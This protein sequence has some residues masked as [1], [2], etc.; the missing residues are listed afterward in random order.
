MVVT[1]LNSSVARW[2]MQEKA[3]CVHSSRIALR[4]YI[5]SLKMKE[6]TNY[7][8]HTAFTAAAS[9]SDGDTAENSLPICDSQTA[10]SAV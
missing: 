1:L 6:T 7:E 4:R 2:N 8:H 5:L 9:P 3:K 10:I